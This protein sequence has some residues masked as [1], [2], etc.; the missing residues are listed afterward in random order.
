MVPARKKRDI[1]AALVA[2]VA[3]VKEAVSAAAAAAAAEVVSAEEVKPLKIAKIADST[4]IQA[5]NESNDAA[6]V[7]AAAPAAAAPATAVATASGVQQMKKEIDDNVHLHVKKESPAE[8]EFRIPGV[9]YTDTDNEAE[10]EDEEEDE[11]E[12]DDDDDEE[13]EEEEE[14]EEEVVEEVY[15]NE[16][17]ASYDTYHANYSAPNKGKVG[18]TSFPPTKAGKTAMIAGGRISLRSGFIKGGLVLR[19]ST[20]N[21][22]GEK[23]GKEG[24]GVVKNSPDTV[25]LLAS[26]YFSLRRQYTLIAS[27]K[28]VSQ[29]K[30]CDPRHT[31]SD[32]SGAVVSV[33]KKKV[34]IKSKYNG[35]QGQVNMSRNE[36]LEL[37]KA[38]N[39][40]W[41]VFKQ[42][43]NSVI[44]D[45][46]TDAIF[47]HAAAIMINSM[48]KGYRGTKIPSFGDAAFRSQ[49]FAAYAF[50]TNFACST[51]VLKRVEA[52]FPAVGNSLDLFTLFHQCVNQIEILCEYMS[53]ISE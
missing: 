32:V 21:E 28:S 49:F 47:K 19:I 5:N 52:K 33:T 7:T 20:S 36:F 22:F 24:H 43:P 42:I 38:L 39:L 13:D 53:T 1:G 15:S 30:L 37:D 4:T 18:V 11:D 34:S 26:E 40:F 51:E 41:F 48:R 12:Y 10:G 2:G 23:Y 35:V 29:F 46:I 8:T 27:T 25:Y 3:A 44:S 31:L 45:A 6:A 9:D 16:A 14:E 50:L 17:S